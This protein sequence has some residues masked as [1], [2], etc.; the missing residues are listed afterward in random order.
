[1]SETDPLT[2][3]FRCPTELEGLIP[4]PVPAPMGVPVEMTSPGLS[5]VQID[6]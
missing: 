3:K 1:M 5:V 4:A 2:L 6:M